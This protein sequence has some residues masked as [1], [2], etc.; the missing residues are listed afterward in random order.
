L[1]CTHDLNGQ[2]LSV[3]PRAEKMLGYE[4]AAM[5]HMNFRDI[6]APEA[7]PGLAL[8]LRR[9]TKRGTAHGQM[10][11]QTKTGERH[12]WEYNNTLRTEGVADPIVR[13]MARDITARKRAEDALRVSEEK[14]RGLVTEISDGIFVTD[15]RGALAFANPALARTLGFEYPDQLMGKNFLEFVAPSMLNEVAGYFRQAIK[16]GQFREVTIVE[17]LRADGTNAIVEI[18]SL[19]IME[20]GKVMGTQGVLRDI[21]E[22]KRVEEEIKKQLD[23][24][25]RWHNATLGRENRVIELKQE[26]NKLLGQDGK[27]PRYTSAET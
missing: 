22:R 3:N 19:P 14:Y 7:L 24:L 16:T 2:I 6:L 21:T 23:E 12:I 18:K 10:I 5:L 20:D 1:I 13:G 17:V 11:V 26:V 27:P 15:D 8:Y 25:Q 4:H 9:I